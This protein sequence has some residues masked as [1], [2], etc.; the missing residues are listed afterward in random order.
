MSNSYLNISTLQGETESGL[1][2]LDEV[3][4]HLWVPLLLKVGDDGLTHQLRV[5]DH[6]QHL[7]GRNMVK[8]DIKC[9]TIMI[10]YN[11]TWSILFEGLGLYCQVTI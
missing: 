1:L 11:S 9:S 4:G 8:F 6:V 5:S 10:I 2:I 7:W 3:Q